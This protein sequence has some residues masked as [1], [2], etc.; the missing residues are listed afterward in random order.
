M[1]ES[2][3]RDVLKKRRPGVIR[4]VAALLAGEL[5]RRPKPKP[6]VPLVYDHRDRGP[7]RLLSKEAR[8]AGVTIPQGDNPARR[9]PWR[10]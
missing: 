2:E 3:F 1:K 9:G 5:F 10:L 4:T 8:A 7:N 6:G